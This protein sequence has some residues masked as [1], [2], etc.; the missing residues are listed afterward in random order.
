MVM[1][2]LHEGP[3]KGHF[4]IEITKRNILDTRYWWPTL[5]RDVNDY[6]ISCDGC[7]RIGG[8][9]IQSFAKLV[10][11]LPKEPFMKWGLH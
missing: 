2:E 3:S 8:S 4:T 10:T 5:Y 7:Q 9:V 6:C 1:R 11:S